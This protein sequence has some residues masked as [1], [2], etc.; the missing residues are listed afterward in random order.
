MTH[1]EHSTFWNFRRFVLFFSPSQ[2][3][4]IQLLSHMAQVFLVQV[5]GGEQNAALRPLDLWQPV[6]Q[7]FHLIFN[8]FFQVIKG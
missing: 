8:N 6:I 5:R 3:F 2:T 7:L 4:I 1:G